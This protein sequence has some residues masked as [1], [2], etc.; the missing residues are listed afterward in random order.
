MYGGNVT[1]DRVLDIRGRK[2][3]FIMNGGTLN[4]N[5]GTLLREGN[6]D[7]LN[8][9]VVN[10][11]TANLGA[12]EINRTASGGGL[13]LSNGVAN[14][15][16]LR[17]GVANSTSYA[18]IYGGVLT[19]TGLFTI[20][21][22]SNGALGCWCVVALWFPQASVVSL[23]PI[24]QTLVL[25]VLL[26]PSQAFSTLMRARS[27]PKASRSSKTTHSPTPTPR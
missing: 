20:C 3:A 15:T 23:S 24:R 27:S 14:T 4:A 25:A 16:S 11:G 17:I 26:L 12:T 6:T 21:D 10:G 22:R 18:T 8:R 19:N 13:I 2:S 1:F 7:D 5:G 9:F